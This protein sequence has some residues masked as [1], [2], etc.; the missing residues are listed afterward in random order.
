[1]GSKRKAEA[2]FSSSKRP[3]QDSAS[4]DNDDEPTNFFSLSAELRNFIYELVHVEKD[5]I[6]ITSTLKEPALLSVCRQI[7]S[8]ARKM[9]YLEN[10]F[11][12]DVR[13]CNADLVNAFERWTR[14]FEWEV[15]A[16]YYG[17]KN[18][19]AGKVS[20]AIEAVDS[21]PDWAGL[22][23]WCERIQR[24]EGV[25][26]INPGQPPSQYS[27][28]VATAHAIV[29]AHRNG[30]WDDCWWPLEELRGLAGLIDRRW[31]D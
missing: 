16:E 21:K 18:W 30:D 3:K 12:A 17:A 7:R 10:Q 2:L 22:M 23:E 8:E 11:V 19:G 15:E 1:M 5:S 25:Q 6:V 31:L 24:D 20:I 27:S 26:P 13:D 9:W 4:R 29:K 14:R 28:I